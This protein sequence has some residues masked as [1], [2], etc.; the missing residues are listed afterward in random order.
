M[1][2]KPRWHWS[3]TRRCIYEDI[4]IHIDIITCTPL[5]R[6][7][8]L[9]IK[10]INLTDRRNTKA[11]P[12]KR[13]EKGGHRQKYSY[14]K[15][16]NS[17]NVHHFDVPDRGGLCAK[18]QKER[19]SSRCYKEYIYSNGMQSWCTYSKLTY[20]LIWIVVSTV[21][22]DENLPRTFIPNI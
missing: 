16:K 10:L 19:V 15:I 14:Y 8:K 1:T 13:A 4:Y 3:A 18:R 20:E 6:R 7:I 2:P 21:C 9:I 17:K 11:R 5:R 22:S 12:Y